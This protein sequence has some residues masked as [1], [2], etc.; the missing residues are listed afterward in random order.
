MKRVLARHGREGLET[1]RN[2]EIGMRAEISKDSHM[3]QP[4]EIQI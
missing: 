3:D 2:A 1:L 4:N